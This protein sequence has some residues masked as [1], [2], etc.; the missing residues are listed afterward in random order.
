MLENTTK[1]GLRVV[2]FLC[3]ILQKMTINETSDLR[4]IRYIFTALDTIFLYEKTRYLL[5][6]ALG[7]NE[8]SQNS[9]LK[10]LKQIVDACMINDSDQAEF[11]RQAKK[12]RNA[13][14]VHVN[15]ILKIS[16]TLNDYFPFS[17]RRENDKK[18]EVLY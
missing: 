1:N 4:C 10:I 3:K 5:P 13:I 15:N 12:L 16:L 14:G 9:C 6:I 8:I 17:N 11:L 2:V 18:Y 7:L